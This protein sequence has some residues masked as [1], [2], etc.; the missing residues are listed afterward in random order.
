MPAVGL[1]AGSAFTRLLLTFHVVV[2][3]ADETLART[4]AEKAEATCLVSA[5][6]DLPV[7]AVIDV[8]T[9]AVESLVPNADP[10]P[11]TPG[12]SPICSTFR[13]GDRA[14][15]FT[16]TK[17]GKALLVRLCVLAT[18]LGLTAGTASAHFAEVAPPPA[19]TTQAGVPA[20][21]PAPD[22]APA[23]KPVVKPKAAPA[24]PKPA[25]APSQPPPPVVSPPP[26]S[27]PPAPV[28]QPTLS[29]AKQ[30]AAKP[31][32]APKR[33]AQ[34]KSTAKSTSHQKHAGRS[35]T[36]G[37]TSLTLHG[38]S[39]AQP[40]VVA[41]SSPLARSWQTPLAILL[42]SIPLLL[43]GAAFVPPNVLPYRKAVAWHDRRVDV[44]SLGGSLLLVEVVIYM[45]L[46]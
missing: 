22:P 42:F 13:R 28:V 2:D 37:V 17:P 9:R 4:L 33:K 23:P 7:E 27:P 8:E 34:P 46:A 36:L 30:V 31:K 32:A 15:T 6:L 20:P 40:V 19:E 45:L 43:I 5:S 35:G 14:M 21:D 38:G 25:P 41:D 44:A 1:T 10:R 18:A 39:S 3:P 29:V 12:A 24:K 11:G 16:R 26:A